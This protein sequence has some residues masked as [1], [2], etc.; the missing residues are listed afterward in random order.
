MS[1]SFRAFVILVILGLSYYL[2]HPTLAYYFFYSP[3][4]RELSET[5]VDFRNEQSGSA[6]LAEEVKLAD[7]HR[8]KAIKLGLDLRGGI[9]ILLEADF[10]K[11]AE[12]TG[13]EV[14]SF[15]DG[16]KRE[17][18]DRVIR[19]IENRIDSA[20]VSE[21]IVR[22][23]GLNRLVIQLPGETSSKRIE[24]IVST[25]GNLEFLL[26]NEAATQALEYDSEAEQVLNLS[27]YSNDYHVYFE[28]KKNELG[29]NEK[30]LPY[31]LEKSVL[32]S[33][34]RIANASFAYGQY[35]EPAV[36]FTLDTTGTPLFAAITST[37]VNNRI[38]IV[39]DGKVIS[40]PSVRQTISGGEGQISGDYTADEANDLALILK[41][42]SLPV[43]IKIISKNVI[44]AK[45]GEDL[46]NRGLRALAIGM[47]LVILLMLFRYRFAGIIASFALVLNAVIIVAFLASFNLTI[48]LSGMA[49]I[50]LTIGMSIDAN[51]II[52]ERIREEAKTQLY[53]SDAIR[54]GYQK[55]FWTIFDSNVTTMISTFI[56]FYYGEGP[57]Q[58]F[59]TTLFIGVIISMF[60]ALFLTRFIFDMLIEFRIIK[61]KRQRI[62]I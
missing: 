36:S 2:L 45:I 57:I 24:D 7:E 56:L 62:I 28:Y 5:E 18:I 27:E 34:E 15:T 48:S 58:G 47:I 8:E 17:A 54:R 19:Q 3:E 39:L 38:A 12:L 16:E 40:A 21:I 61:G 29:R 55:A 11:L 42:G 52:Y 6:S 49:G 50:L 13:R 32:M 60:T 4:V 10:V 23:K 59:A 43:P 44:A 14:D 37:N 41:S 33:G 9:N 51:V 22:K 53:L 25:T 31:A 26:V 20:G 30:Y 35:G 46:K 1:F